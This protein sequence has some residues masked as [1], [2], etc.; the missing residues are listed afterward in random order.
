MA[1]STTFTTEGP[2]FDRPNLK[3]Q[4][5]FDR[6]NLKQQETTALTS[7]N[8]EPHHRFSPVVHG[9]PRGG[10]GVVHGQCHHRWR[11]AA[12]LRPPQPQKKHDGH[13]TKVSTAAT[14]PQ[15][16]VDGQLRPWPV[17][18]LGHQRPKRGRQGGGHVGQRRLFGNVL[19]PTRLRGTHR[20]VYGLH[21]PQFTQRHDQTVV[22]HVPVQPPAPVRRER[23]QQQRRRRL[24]PVGGAVQTWGDDPKPARGEPIDSGVGFVARASDAIS[25]TFP[26]RRR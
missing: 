10:L 24:W 14:H 18:C 6:P 21:P 1:S 17:Q 11:D 19:V 5:T 12:P 20:I 3:Q 15:R 7:K 23:E 2:S 26:A 9:A 22:L 13:A 25:T 4:E 8:H 16:R